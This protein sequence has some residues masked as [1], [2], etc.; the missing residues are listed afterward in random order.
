MIM[1]LINSDIRKIFLGKIKNFPR[2]I[3][4]EKPSHYVLTTSE[5]LRYIF[6]LAFKTENILIAGYPRNQ[7]LISDDIKNIYLDE[8][9]RDR[10][11][12]IKFFEKKNKWN[13]IKKDFLYANI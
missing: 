9:N 5:N 13:E 6:S 11:K 7:V 1:F 12:I 10:K 2:N 4:D 8:E 3:S